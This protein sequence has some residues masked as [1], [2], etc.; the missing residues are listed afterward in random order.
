[1]T[2]KNL[3]VALKCCVQTYAWGKHGSQSTV[4]R[5][6]QNNPEFQLDEETSYAEVGLSHRN[7]EY[8]KSGKFE[9]CV[10]KIYEFNAKFR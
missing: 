4:A 9:N 10:T 7:P 1:M 5:L 2:F 6:A 3:A 8:P